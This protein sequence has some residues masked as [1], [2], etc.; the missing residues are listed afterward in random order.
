MRFK[1]VFASFVLAGVLLQSAAADQSPAVDHLIQKARSLEA[2]DR[3]DLAAREELRA[4]TKF[5]GI[6]AMLFGCTNKVI[7]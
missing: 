5:E 6:Y 7:E 3:A 2:R 4:G 1:A